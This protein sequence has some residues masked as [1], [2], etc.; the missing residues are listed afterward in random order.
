MKQDWQQSKK[1]LSDDPP[2][3]PLCYA[4]ARG[5]DKHIQHQPP[6]FNQYFLGDGG[7][8]VFISWGFLSFCLFLWWLHKQ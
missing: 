3:M 5:K 8:V 7:V 6:N 1:E 4:A 2:A